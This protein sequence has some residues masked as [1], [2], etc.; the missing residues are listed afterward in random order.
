MGEPRKGTAM[1]I[2]IKT[3]GD[4]YS[5]ALTG[6]G[7]RELL[8][9]DL[10]GK[11]RLSTMR[12]AA[13]A[14]LEGFK[15][16]VVAGFKVAGVAGRPDSYTVLSDLA[17]SLLSILLGDRTNQYVSTFY[18]FVGESFL[19][20]HA[21]E[22]TVPRVTLVAPP[23]LMVPIE[24]LAFRGIGRPPSSADL[25]GGYYNHL[26]FASVV[27]RSFSR[28]PD[29]S[30]SRII[31]GAPQL[32]V[33][34]LQNTSLPG[35]A[36]EAKFLA[37]NGRIKLD[38]PWPDGEADVS[39]GLEAV[40]KSL[41]DP[42]SPLKAN[43]LQVAAQIQH[44]SCHG[45]FD[46]KDPRQSDLRL[47]CQDGTVILVLG[48]LEQ[49]FTRLRLETKKPTRD[50]PLVFLNACESAATAGFMSADSFPRHFRDWDSRAV[51]GVETTVPDNIAAAFSRLFYEGLLDADL[52]LGEAVLQA[53]QRLL[54]RN[55]P[56]GILYTLYGDPDLVVMPPGSRTIS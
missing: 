4:R 54:A 15:R 52:S 46:P 31:Q 32:P 7:G 14:G 1:T 49:E 19:K 20:W 8:L 23:D 16:A 13:M 28:L 39:A 55:N 3:D 42:T 5:L 24:L 10:A 21:T 50:V 51:L 47:S 30:E 34:F 17:M 41:Y 56:L 44:L 27:N 37:G 25:N 18:D 53:R 6:Y 36:R 38:G 12:Q 11:Q 45:R 29:V 35:S 22:E 2:E 40:I 33:M 9:P 26:G 48:K 43:P